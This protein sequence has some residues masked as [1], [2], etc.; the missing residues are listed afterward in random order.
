M[1]SNHLTRNYLKGRL[2][3]FL[4]L[5]IIGLCLAFI[6]EQEPSTGGALYGAII[7]FGMIPSRGKLGEVSYRKQKVRIK[8][9]GDNAQYAQRTV[10]FL[11]AQTNTSNTPAQERQR[12]SFAL[13]PGIASLLN[14]CGIIQAYWT[15][16][17]S[18][19]PYQDFLSWHLRN[20]IH[21]CKTGKQYVDFRKVRPV[22]G[23]ALKP[24]TVYNTPAGEIQ[25]G[26]D[27]TCN[28]AI[29]ARWAYQ[30]SKESLDKEAQL[31]AISLNINA[32]GKMVEPTIQQFNV[33]LEDCEAHILLKNSECTK[34]YTYLFFANMDNTYYTTSVYIG[35]EAAEYAELPEKNCCAECENDCC[36]CVCVPP[37]EQPLFCCGY[38]LNINTDEFLYEGGADIIGG[39]NANRVFYPDPVKE[40]CACKC[41]KTFVTPEQ[42]EL[43]ANALQ[44]QYGYTDVEFNSESGVITIPHA[45]VVDTTINLSFSTEGENGLPVFSQIVLQ[46]V[47]GACEDELKL[48]KAVPQ[49][50]AGFMTGTYG[51]NES[52][53]MVGADGE[54]KGFQNAAELIEILT[55]LYGPGWYLDSNSGNIM[56]SGNTYTFA[57]DDIVFINGDEELGEPAVLMVFNFVPCKPIEPI[58]P[59]GGF[60]RENEVIP[61]PP[62]G[63]E[64]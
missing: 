13:M 9:Q 25:E 17:N 46:F 5:L 12:K 2:L 34:S 32:E 61:E 22:Y 51:I 38:D 27:L 47:E 63:E 58:N 31:I 59:S 21:I 37:D 16:M 29:T 4:K 6:Y 15:G 52:S 1:N 18:F 30:C 8:G 49:C 23:N 3:L 60:N 26:A 43:V 39:E 20:A 45:N 10:A 44:D 64:G 55:D 42:A 48:S 7:G 11:P 50:L 35:T 36:E 40:D 33:K 56:Y 24:I 54:E 28:R 19:R 62:D 14:R 57:G 53:A 41:W